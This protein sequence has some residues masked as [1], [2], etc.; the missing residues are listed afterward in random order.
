MFILKKSDMIRVL[1]RLKSDL[2][3]NATSR[4]FHNSHHRLLAPAHSLYT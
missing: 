3:N 2:K 4:Y 1:N